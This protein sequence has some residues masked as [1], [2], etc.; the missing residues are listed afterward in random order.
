MSLTRIRILLTKEHN[1]RR[2][3]RGLEPLTESETLNTIAQ[4]YAKALCRAGYISHELDGSKLEERYEAGNYNYRLWG[5]NLG[6][7][8]T[9]IVQ[10]L[11][12]LTT[13]LHHRENMYEPE[14]REIG[15]GQC[16][17]IWVINYGTLAE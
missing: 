12:Q 17:D 3:Q 4:T 6:S 8:Q 11:D 9:T 7:G 15:I 14:F 2:I 13:S 16:R 10:L 5:E 1:Q